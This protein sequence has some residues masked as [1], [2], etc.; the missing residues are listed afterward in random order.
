MRKLAVLTIAVACVL[1]AWA[2][3]PA[4]ADPRVPGV[5]AWQLLQF[6]NNRELYN[7]GCLEWV[8]QMQLWY[9]RC[10]WNYR[11]GPV[12]TAKY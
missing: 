2:S 11:R 12:V 8:F 3:T 1:S 9:N 7:A 6:G 5:R 4:Q 10:A